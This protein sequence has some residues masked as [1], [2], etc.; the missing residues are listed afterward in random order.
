MGN[1]EAVVIVIARAGGIE[2]FFLEVGTEIA[3]TDA[4]TA[5]TQEEIDRI[6][7][8]APVHGIT[9]FP[10]AGEAM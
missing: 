3:A 9:M 6:L 5:P 2:K 4:P 8:F 1:E 7:A 10:Q